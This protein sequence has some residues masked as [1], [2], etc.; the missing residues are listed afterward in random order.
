[1][2][3]RYLDCNNLVENVQWELYLDSSR[4]RIWSNI[5]KSI[6]ILWPW[7]SVK[8]LMT[9]ATRTNASFKCAPFLNNSTFELYLETSAKS[10]DIIRSFS[11]F[12][13]CKLV[14]NWHNIY[15]KHSEIWNQSIT[16]VWKCFFGFWVFMLFNRGC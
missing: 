5:K 4:F 3:L 16:S 13:P 1:M 10:L 15:T 12:W 11:I 8:F 2:Y 9:W 14:L 7:L 6:K